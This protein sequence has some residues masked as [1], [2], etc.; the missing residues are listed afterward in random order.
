[1][2]R[3]STQRVGKIFTMATLALCLVGATSVGA[4]VAE[5]EIGDSDIVWAPIVNFDKAVLTVSG[6]S[7]IMTH[8]FNAGEMPYLEV[9][10]LVDGSYT[11]ELRTQPVIDAATQAPLPRD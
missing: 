9:F 4:Q 6:P 5:L 7:G 1:M 3:A 8:E 2:S 11:W 10:D